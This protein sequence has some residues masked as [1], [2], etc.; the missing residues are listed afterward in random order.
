MPTT[1]P[2]FQISP[3]CYKSLVILLLHTAPTPP[4]CFEARLTP[5]RIG[6]DGSHTVKAWESTTFDFWCCHFSAVWLPFSE[7]LR[8]HDFWLYNF[9]GCRLAGLASR[10]S[11]VQVRHSQCSQRLK[12]KKTNKI[13]L[14]YKSLQT[15]IVK[16][17]KFCS[18][19]LRGDKF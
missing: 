11:R 12:E 16:I 17:T 3:K 6:M 14:W 1:T 9:H 2:F 15:K 18:K 5:G 4:P 7:G 13:V 8:G 19:N 10:A